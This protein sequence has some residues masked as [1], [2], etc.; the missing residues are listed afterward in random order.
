MIVII[1]VS[2]SMNERNP[3]SK[4]TAAPHGVA[5]SSLGGSKPKSKTPAKRRVKVSF[6]EA[7]KLILSEDT[8]LLRR[9]AD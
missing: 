4:V 5:G 2:D 7:V 1:F 3:I 8:P 9:L 6:D